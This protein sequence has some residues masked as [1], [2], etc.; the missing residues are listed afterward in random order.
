L[1]GRQSFKIGVRGS[2]VWSSGHELVCPPQGASLLADHRLQRL[3]RRVRT[4]PAGSAV[5]FAGMPAEG[6]SPPRYGKINAFRRG[7]GKP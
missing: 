7:F 1:S 3:R 2:S 6:T 4:A 5:L